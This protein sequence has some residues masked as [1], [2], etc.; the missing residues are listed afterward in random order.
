[1]WA[2]GRSKQQQISSRKRQYWAWSLKNYNLH[3]HMDEQKAVALKGNRQ[4]E[5]LGKLP[6]AA[7]GF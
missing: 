1:M 3:R 5:K 2:R 7:E 6:K 4:P